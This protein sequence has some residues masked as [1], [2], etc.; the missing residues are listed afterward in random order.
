MD[1]YILKLMSVKFQITLPDDLA[2][3][4]KQARRGRGSLWRN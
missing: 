2:A 4:L 1:H 3:A